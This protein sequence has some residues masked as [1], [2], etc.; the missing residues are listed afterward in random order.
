MT[1]LSAEVVTETLALATVAPEWRQLWSRAPDAIPFSSPDWLLPWWDIFHP[2]ELR[3]ILI[4]ERGRLVGVAPLYREQ[5][6]YGRRLLPM[7]IGVSDYLDVLIDPAWRDAVAE[8]VGQI[9]GEMIDI[10]SCEFADLP[11]CASALKIPVGKKHSEGAHQA[12]SCPVLRLPATAEALK[13]TI[14]PSRLRH[15]RNA[16]NRARRMGETAVVRGDAGN[17]LSLLSDLIRLHSFRWS[18]DGGGVFADSRVT[19]FHTAALPELMRHNIARLYAIRIGETVAAV[20]YGFLH[21]SSAY[22]YLCGYD[23][24]FAFV[25]PGSILI[26]H[27]IEEAVREGAR[28]FHFLRGRESYKYEWGAIDRFNTTRTIRLRNKKA[29]HG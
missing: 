28:D 27:A 25:S 11:P 20:Y 3:A 9:I 29:A 14:P 13:T 18:C 2:G 1:C 8:N 24:E 4:R 19:E 12:S 16:R 22:A 23:P 6:V 10:D 26:G 21:R 17:A 5:G 7:G 15:L